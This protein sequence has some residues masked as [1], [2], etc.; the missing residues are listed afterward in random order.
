MT[1]FD[2]TAVPSRK[3]RYLDAVAAIRTLDMINNGAVTGTEDPDV[4]W[5]WI[6]RTIC[7]PRFRSSVSSTSSG[8]NRLPRNTRGIVLTSNPAGDC[9]DVRIGTGWVDYLGLATTV[10]HIGRM[11]G[12]LGNPVSS[13]VYDGGTVTIA[14]AALHVYDPARA[15]EFRDLMAAVGL[16]TTSTPKGRTA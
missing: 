10:A 4:K 16:R 7:D 8:I 15:T 3:E 6:V 2:R 11:H 5:A 14:A 13:T 1:I 12:W 9:I